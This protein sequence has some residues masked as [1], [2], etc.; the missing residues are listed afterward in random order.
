MGVHVMD[1]LPPLASYGPCVSTVAL[2]PTL[3]PSE[4]VV[5]SHMLSMNPKQTAITQFF[6]K[7]KQ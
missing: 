7:Q 4:G 5:A 1:T 6:K 2:P 3:P